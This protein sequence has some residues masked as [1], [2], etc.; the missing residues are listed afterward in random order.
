MTPF[1]PLMRHPLDFCEQYEPL[2]KEWEA[3]TALRKL[4]VEIVDLE[5]VCFV[6]VLLSFFACLVLFCLSPLLRIDATVVI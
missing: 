2:K 4:K 1:F 3:T 5:K 6:L